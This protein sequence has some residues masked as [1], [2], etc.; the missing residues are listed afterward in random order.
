VTLQLDRI[1]RF[2]VTVPDLEAG[3]AALTRLGVAV[4]TTGD[5]HCV[6]SVGGPDNVVAV[7]FVTERAHKRGEADDPCLLVFAVDDPAAAREFLDAHPAVSGAVGCRFVFVDE[8]ATAGERSPSTND[9]PLRRLDHLAILPPDLEAATRH[10]SDGFGVPMHAELT[11]P[12]LIIRQMPVGDV[13]V[14]L[15]APAS[16]DSHLAALAPGMRPLI[17]CEVDDVT[18]CVAQARDRG[19]TVPDPA[20][21]FLP[22][23]MTA[24]IAPDEVAGLAIQLLEY[25]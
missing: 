12:T 8:R 23:T 17:A 3:E 11:S 5:E 19:F 2:V 1:D 15:L 9:F 24:T 25:V 22:G 10:W 20:P 6:F 4:S 14:E 21:G 16:P 13:M 7:E 18:V